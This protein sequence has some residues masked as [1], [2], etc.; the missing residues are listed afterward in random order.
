[1]NVVLIVDEY[2][3]QRALIEEQLCMHDVTVLHEGGIAMDVLRANA[4]R[5]ALVLLDV[6]IAGIPD[7]DLLWQISNNGTLAHVPIIVFGDGDELRE[8]ALQLGAVGFA[9]TDPL[10]GLMTE[11]QKHLNCDGEVCERQD[12]ALI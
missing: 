9:R 5:L 10:D 4:N 7:L 11:V 3:T 1:M 6:S 8:R 12:L 2:A